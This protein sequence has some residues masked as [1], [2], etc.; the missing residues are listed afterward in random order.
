MSNI[1]YNIILVTLL[2]YL[3][4]NI[5]KYVFSVLQIKLFIIIKK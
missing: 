2:H 3:S 4:K 5:T 1:L